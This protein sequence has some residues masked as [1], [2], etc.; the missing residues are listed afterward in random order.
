M[1]AFNPQ[2]VRCANNLMN[3]EEDAEDVVMIVW[4]R[5][6]AEMPFK[7]DKN[8]GKFKTWAYTILKNEIYKTIYN[9]NRKFAVKTVSSD[10]IS[11]DT[12]ECTTNAFDETEYIYYKDGGMIS[13]STD[14]IL[15]SL[16][17]LSRDMI[18]YLPIRESSAMTE[19][20]IN[21]RSCSDIAR[22]Y[23]VN[24]GTLWKWIDSGKKHVKEM[25]RM[26]LPQYYQLIDE[27]Y[28]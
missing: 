26:E 13:I 27:I 7:Y 22:E 15:E 3:N 16:K 21:G 1:E 6:W 17:K 9:K 14:E 28:I 23:K 8:K 2:M 20:Y 11:L 12:V 19:M 4:E 18:Q 5:L 10:I 24:K 25:L